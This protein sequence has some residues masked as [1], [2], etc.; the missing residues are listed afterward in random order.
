MAIVVIEVEKVYMAIN[1]YLI[2]KS[3]GHH[4]PSG[5]YNAGSIIYDTAKVYESMNMRSLALILVLCLFAVC[6]LPMSTV[7]AQNTPVINDDATILP[8]V[9]IDY[10]GMTLLTST[11]TPEQQSDHRRPRDWIASAH[12]GST[13]GL[14]GCQ[15]H[16]G[17]HGPEH[18]C[19]PLTVHTL[20]THRE[21]GR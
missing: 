9:S 19:G 2:V 20:P 10:E 4:D 11:A 5:F 15:Y 17:D 7:P 8:I 3:S 18:H 6:L 21:P 14:Q 16:L 13:S 1:C 12:R